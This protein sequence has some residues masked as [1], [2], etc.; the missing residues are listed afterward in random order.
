MQ[1]QSDIIA[2]FMYI[3]PLLLAVIHASSSHKLL[4]Q[5]L[6]FLTVDCNHLSRNLL[7]L[8]RDVPQ[9][10]AKSVLFFFT[11]SLRAWKDFSQCIKS[12]NNSSL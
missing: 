1:I 2:Q 4:T 7:P 9:T 8:Y 6:P 5:F 11:M 10:I 3:T 12:P